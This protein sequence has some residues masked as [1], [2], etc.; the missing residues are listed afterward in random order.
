MQLNKNIPRINF[1]S[2]L[3]LTIKTMFYTLI[4]HFTFNT[5]DTFQTNIYLGCSTLDDNLVVEASLEYC[6]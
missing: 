5:V 2:N 6:K 4:T 3:T 1:L